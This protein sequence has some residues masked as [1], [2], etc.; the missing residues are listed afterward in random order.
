ML[1]LATSMRFAISLLTILA[2]ASIV[3]T[4]L[5]QNE[6]YFNYLDQ[7]GTF[8]VSLHEVFML[9]CMITALMYLLLRTAL[10]NAL[11]GIVCPAR[12]ARGEVLEWWLLVG[13][14]RDNIR[15]SRSY[16][17]LSGLRSYGQL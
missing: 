15:L 3:G 8:W 6:P 2:I 13:I 11:S 1:E 10:C 17:S 7:V 16:I 14:A 9:F 12:H 5:R 4:A